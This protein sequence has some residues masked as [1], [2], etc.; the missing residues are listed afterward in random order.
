MR[1]RLVV[2]IVLA[3]V[4]LA[5]STWGFADSATGGS[6]TALCPCP[7]EGVVTPYAPYRAPRDPRIW[8]RQLGVVSEA[9]RQLRTAEREFRAGRMSLEEYRRFKRALVGE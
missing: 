3:Q 6:A 7:P 9:D 5:P 4:A 8:S 1:V 2:A